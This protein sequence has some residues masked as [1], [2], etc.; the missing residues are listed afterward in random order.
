MSKD[1]FQRWGLRSS[2]VRRNLRNP[3]FQK[4]AIALPKR[5]RRHLRRAGTIALAVLGAGLIAVGV[6]ELV[7]N[8][9]F[10]IKDPKYDFG[11]LSQEKSETARKIVDKE[12]ASSFFLGIRLNNYFLLRTNR[13]KAAVEKDIANAEVRVRKKFP[14]QIAVFFKQPE[15]VFFVEENGVKAFLSG[16]GIVLDVFDA[17]SSA[18]LSDKSFATSSL[19]RVTLEHDA[20]S[21]V[22]I[23]MGQKYIPLNCAT[24]IIQTAERLARSGISGKYDVSKDATS[25]SLKASEG[26]YLITDP[27]I[28]S[29]D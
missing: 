21:T 10:E 18:F 5:G 1:R 23:T 28:G 7:T 26:W 8:P 13:I 15:K 17:S 20:S 11:N 25:V 4:A 2:K 6:F 27:I 22:Q 24:L 3:Y 9:Y 16:E 12:L 14:N 29:D 19:I